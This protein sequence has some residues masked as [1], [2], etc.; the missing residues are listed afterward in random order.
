MKKSTAFERMRTWEWKFLR[1]PITSGSNLIFC[2]ILERRKLSRWSISRS[3]THLQCRGEQAPGRTQSKYLKWDDTFQK[4]HFWDEQTSLT[5]G[6]SVI[7]RINSCSMCEKWENITTRVSITQNDEHSNS[8]K[9]SKLV[10]DLYFFG[11]QY[12]QATG[13]DEMLT[14]W[15]QKSERLIWC[16]I[17]DQIRTLGRIVRL[18]SELGN[19]PV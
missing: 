5:V 12:S 13:A 2:H 16:F 18:S 17:I 6:T 4:R 1:E 7:M 3:N 15:K 19:L 14:K 10:I 9:N 11:V 8:K